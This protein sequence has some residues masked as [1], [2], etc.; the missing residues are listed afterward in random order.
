[1][2]NIFFITKTTKKVVGKI[3]EEKKNLQS[4]KSVILSVTTWTSSN[5]ESPLAVIS[6]FINDE[7]NLKT[8][9]LGV[10]Y[11]PKKHTTKIWQR[12]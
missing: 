3:C 12:R 8:A 2:F 10:L 9:L 7:T 5:T 6:H 4:V 11:L 1:M